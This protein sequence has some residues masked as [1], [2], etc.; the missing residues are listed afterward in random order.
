MTGAYFGIDLGTTNCKVGAFDARGGLLF[1]EERPTACKLDF[2]G[3]RVCDIRQ[4]WEDVKAML[5]LAAERYT[6]LSIGIAGM[7]EPGLLL[8]PVTGE[9]LTDVMLWNDNRSAEYAELAEQKTD[10]ME[11]FCTTGLPAS[12]KYGVY[13][14]LTELKY[15]NLSPE[16]LKWLPAESYLLCCLTGELATDQTLALRTHAYN[17]EPRSYD[18]R[19]LQTMGLPPDIFPPVMSSGEKM[20]NLRNTFRQA[21]HTAAEVP[22]SVCGHDHLCAFYHAC[23]TSD[24]DM[25]LSLGTTGVLLGSFPRRKLNRNDYAGGYSFGLHVNPEYMSW[26][27]GIQS[28]GSAVD[29]CIRLLGIKNFE[30]F[31][32][33]ARTAAEPETDPLFYPYLNGCGAPNL[34]ARAQGSFLGLNLSQGPAEIIHGVL[35]GLAYELRYMYDHSPQEKRPEAIKAFGGVTKNQVLMQMIADVLG[36]PV[37][38]PAGR[39]MTLAGAAMLAAPEIQ[40]SGSC[41]TAIRLESDP[42][43]FRRYDCCYHERYLPERDSVRRI[44]RKEI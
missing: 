22:V 37:E 33:L 43:L 15:R 30:Q 44:S 42:E 6:P 20:G 1:L 4:V 7:S 16:G 41:S 9:V 29:W 31:H 36:C 3:C 38:V 8:N 18:R 12:A 21:W 34:D 26:L 5:T 35:E 11:R 39:E 19:F 25:T 40:W 27:A 23:G 17:L 14:L 13:K 24:R 28:A 32:E 10:A 2:M